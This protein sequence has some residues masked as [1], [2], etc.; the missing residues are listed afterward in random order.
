MKSYLK[1]SKKGRDFCI[2]RVYRERLMFF[3][4]MT[5]TVCTISFIILLDFALNVSL[6]LEVACYMN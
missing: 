5:F 4:Y 3:V 6:I 1:K 2:N